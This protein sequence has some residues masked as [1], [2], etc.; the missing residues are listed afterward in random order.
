MN[1]PTHGVNVNSGLTPALR[2]AFMVDL[3]GFRVSWVFQ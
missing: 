3:R 1:R 2:A